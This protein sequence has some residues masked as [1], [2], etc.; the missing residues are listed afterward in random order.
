MNYF[1]EELYNN[2]PCGYHFLDK[3]GIFIRINDTELQMLGY[4]REEVLGRKFSEFITPESLPTF[5]NNFPIWK[6]G[7]WVNDLEF[8]MRCK[9]SS[10]LPISLSATAIKDEAG[11][12]LMSQSVVINISKRKQVELTLSQSEAKY[13]NLFNSIDQGVI[14]CDVIFDKNDRPVDI[15][16]VE[17]NTTAR[18]MNDQKLPGRWTSDIIPDFEHDWFEVFADVALT[19]EAVRMELPATHLNTW[20]EFYIFRPDKERKKRVVLIYK[21]ITE[22]KQVEQERERFLAIGLDLQVIVGNK[23][24]FY[25][26][27][28]TCEQIL[29]WTAEEMISFPWTEFIHPE[30]IKATI[31]EAA[32]LFAGKITLDFENRYR[33]KNGFYRWL[34]WR[35]SPYPEEQ[36]LYGTAVDIT[37][38]KEAELRLQQQIARQNLIAEITEAMYQSFDVEQILQFTV[39][40]VRQLLQTERVIIFRFDPDWSGIVVAESV[41]SGWT[42][43]L[44]SRITD[45]CF[46]ED[47]VEP[48]RQG[49]V[50]MNSDFIGSDVESCYK[51]LMANFQ[52]RATLVVPILERENLWGLAIAHHCSAPRQWQTEEVEL[53]QQLAT[54]LGIAIQKSELYQK[55]AEQ[56]ALIDIASDAIFVRDLSHRIKFWSQGAERLY[57]WKEEE[58]INQV[59]QEL[60][61]GESLAQLE[62]ALKITLEEGNW[63]GELKQL[64]KKS[65]EIIVESRWTLMRDQQGH[66]ESILMVNTDITEK[67]ELS[68]QLLHAQR[69]ENIGTLA[70]GIAHD[71][72]NI[73]TPILGF[74]QLL[75]LK[76]PNLDESSLKLLKIIRNNAQ[77]GADIIKQVLLFSREIA[78]QWELVNLAQVLEEVVNLMRRTFPKLIVIENYISPNLWLV[79]GD[80][81]QLHQVLMNLCVNARDAMP[82]GGKLV[83]SAEN[84]SLDKQYSCTNLN[85]EVGNYILITVTDTGRGIPPEIIDRIFDPFFTTK[86]PGQGTGLGLSTVLGIIKNHGGT[87]QVESDRR[88][89]T[90]FKIYLPAS[91]EIEAT[92]TTTVETVHCGQGELIL[93][94]DDETPIREI[95][96][97]TLETH[98]YRVITANDGIDAIAVY[99]QHIQEIEVVLMDIIMPEMD[100]FTAMRA[101]K[102]I[103]PNV[104]LIATSG[105]ATQEKICAAELIGAKSFLPKPYTAEKLLLNLNEVIPDD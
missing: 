63:N 17:A 44:K 25:W 67:K 30:D 72:N 32:D 38:R 15:L 23:G 36:I 92:E 66:P 33:H 91:V 40:G 90:Q 97:A 8:Q 35:A 52:V 12:Y 20:Y 93:V 24:Y 73:L 103:N 13:R 53:L 55:N 49:R 28:P 81:T 95:T 51:E 105:L 4:S 71:L 59:V 1:P 87:I 74:A 94:V 70:G 43:I 31:T 99:A 46:T 2:L 58:V 42:S 101:L 76:I 100:G 102:K 48:Y 69:L 18:K 88:S 104:K 61:H 65:Q 19:G 14:F 11:N 7:G 75:P 21:D 56:A 47:Y 60:F 89:G 45:P 9:D 79:Q 27:S 83:V 29:G 54:Q 57:G 3:N 68:Q 82:D 86:E 84:L 41:A 78:S 96:K 10:I 26:V 34:L 39:E 80:S 85:I 5:Q 98:N 22:P 6:Q 16:Y 62:T 37:E 64:T 77:R 50:Y